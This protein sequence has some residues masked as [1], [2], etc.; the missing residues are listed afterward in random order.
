MADSARLRSSP[1]R[2]ASRA[3]SDCCR[4]RNTASRSVRA[5][6]ACSCSAASIADCDAAC[7]AWAVTCG[8]MATVERRIRALT[9]VRMRLVPPVR[10]DCKQEIMV[11]LCGGAHSGRP[12]ASSQGEQEIVMRKPLSTR[13]HGMIDHTW[14]A[15]ATALSARHDATSTARLLQRAA[16]VARTSS[17]M[18][19]YENGTVR[20]LPVKA[21][22]AVDVALCTVLIASP[23]ILPESERRFAAIPVALGIIGL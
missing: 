18:T 8:W 10:R 14:L 20:L 21:H 16:A 9:V 6:T 11:E 19:N 15:A 2:L 17:M 22:L 4:T 12:L 23:W 3:T 1:I 13:A 5:D 7:G